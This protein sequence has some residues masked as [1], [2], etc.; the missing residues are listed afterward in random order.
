MICLRCGY[1]CTNSVVV[2]VDDP[3]KGIREDN[4]K[5]KHSGERCQHMR[6]NKV[7]E[8]SCSIHNEKWYK[9]TPCAQHGQIES[10]NSDCRMGA[11][12]LKKACSVVSG[13]V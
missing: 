5:V 4:L 3:K 10:C 13:V 11:F 7:G 6:G 9:K 2:I 12:I 8:Y 1:C